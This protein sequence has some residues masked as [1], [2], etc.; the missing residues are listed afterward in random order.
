MYSNRE[1]ENETYH[2]LEYKNSDN[3]T[4]EKQI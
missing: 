2:Y 4:P 3:D 1:G